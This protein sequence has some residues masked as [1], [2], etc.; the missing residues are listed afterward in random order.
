MKNIIEM[1]ITVQGIMLLWMMMS[2]SGIYT[3]A[4]FAFSN[5]LNKV[6]E[7]VQPEYV[8]LAFDTNKKTFRHKEFDFYKANRKS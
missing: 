3:N 2:K 5:M 7:T 8:L 6:L 4:L 1:G